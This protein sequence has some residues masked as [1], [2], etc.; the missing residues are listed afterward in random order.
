MH[1]LLFCLGKVEG[2]IL[3]IHDL[4]ESHVGITGTKAEPESQLC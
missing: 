1:H 2:L 4:S 3:I